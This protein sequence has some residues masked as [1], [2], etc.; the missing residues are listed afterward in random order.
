MKRA[1][2][3]RTRIARIGAAA[4]VLASCAKPA[5][6]QQK[7]GTR[8]EVVKQAPSLLPKPEPALTRAELIV[9]AL[10]ALTAAAA[11]EDDSDSQS[12]LK[13]R[14]FEA[15]IRF[16][17]SGA[18]AKAPNGWVYDSKKE[19]LRVRAN[20]DID[21]K[22]LEPSDLLTR[23]YEGATGFILRRPWL[24]TASCPTAQFGA[25]ADGPTIAIVQSFSKSDS[26]VQRPERKFEAVVPDAGD[27]LPRLG[28]D[29]VL[30]GRLEPLADNRPIHC[31]AAQG[32]PVCIVSSKIDRVAIEDP[33]RDAVLAEWTPS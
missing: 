27:R 23:D 5:H 22:S 16:G 15:R 25:L 14:R 33:A 12:K 21:G 6:Q 30:A 24:L 4:L 13:G 1:S 8:P 11:G 3:Q 31:A 2:L 17:C 10:R 32:A 7:A 19:V 18:D 28:L 20:A 9:A 26:R 29:L